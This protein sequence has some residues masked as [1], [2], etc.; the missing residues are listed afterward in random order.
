MSAETKTNYKCSTLGKLWLKG[1]RRGI[2]RL[3]VNRGGGEGGRARWRRGR[4]R[5]E[6]RVR[7]REGRKGDNVGGREMDWERRRWPGGRERGGWR[8]R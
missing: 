6:G 7:Q 8:K 1:C 3:G 4:E 2:S 5:E